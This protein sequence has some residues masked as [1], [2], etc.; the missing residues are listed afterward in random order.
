MIERIVID[1]YRRFSRLDLE[2]SPGMNIVVGDNESGKLTLLEAIALALTGKI[3]GRWANE[4]LNPFWFHRPTVLKFFKT[5]GSGEATAPP[6]VLIEIYLSDEID[7]LQHLRGVHNTL[8]IDCP[9]VAL[10]VA[11]S[12]D[13]RAELGAYM[14][15]EPPIVLP[16]EF[17]E[18][19]WRDFADNRL[20]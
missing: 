10:A 11:P 2:P 19:D 18:V 14:N 5:Y 9:G 1:G 3:N 4:E 6:R 16:V 12:E 15:S 7:A 20:G 17:Y 8:Q 13:Y